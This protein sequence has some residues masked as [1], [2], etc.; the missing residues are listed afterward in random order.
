MTSSATGFEVRDLGDYRLKGI[1]R[2]ERL[3]Q[4]VAP[5]LAFDFAP[6]QAQRLGNLPLPRTPLV[7]RRD[8]TR[9]IVD[10]L[11]QTP[12]LTLTGPGGVG[13]TR[14]AVEVA[15]TVVPSYGDGAFF[16]GLASVDDPDTVA[17]V[18]ARTLGLPRSRARP[19][20]TRSCAACATASC[21]WCW[22]TSS[23]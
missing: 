14:L 23:G 11:A 16:V 2:P 1:P 4:L 5:G 7:G 3:F 15:R 19:R 6:L 13:K 20:P 17:A 10:A 22:T 9:Q 18:V 8:E 21:S 12:L